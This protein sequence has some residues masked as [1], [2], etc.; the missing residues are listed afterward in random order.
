MRGRARHKS[1][2]DL[3]ESRATHGTSDGLITDHTSS[4][5]P[6]SLAPHRR[7]STALRV[8]PAPSPAAA[9]GPHPNAM[10]RTKQTATRKDPNETPRRR[11]ATKKLPR[12]A[13][14]AAAPVP[15]KRHYRPGTKVLRDIR[16]FQRT[17]E[18]L[19]PKLPFGRLVRELADNYKRDLRFQPAA[20]E[21][22]QEACEAYLLTL[23]EDSVL[24]ARHAKR[25]TMQ[26]RDMRLAIRIRGGDGA[27]C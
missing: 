18:L 10:A 21:A 12:R 13:S 3:A 2:K 22:L 23:F 17:T 9:S 6:R 11:R 24:C 5:T 1:R 26:A 8:L 4:P 19:L 15:P 20:V 7:S 27:R 16:R 25:V 14:Q